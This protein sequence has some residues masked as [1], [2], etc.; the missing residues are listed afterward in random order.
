M[1]IFEEQSLHGS[2]IVTDVNQVMWWFNILSWGP[3]RRGKTW[4]IWGEQRG[5]ERWGA[6][7]EREGAHSK[8]VVKQE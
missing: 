3:S 1:K 5:E 7:G 8:C 2:V 4:G 6:W